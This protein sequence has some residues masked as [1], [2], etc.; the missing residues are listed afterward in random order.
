[1][2]DNLEKVAK[3]MRQSSQANPSETTNSPTILSNTSQMRPGLKSI[4]LVSD[5]FVVS[6]R[7]TAA[8]ASRVLFNL[9]IISESVRSFILR[10][11]L[12]LK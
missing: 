7:A 2:N 10:L 6:D 9:R 12:S 4:A 3:A 11:F 1:M 5:R 8:T